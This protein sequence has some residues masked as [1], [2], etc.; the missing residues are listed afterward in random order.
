MTAQDSTTGKAQLNLFSRDPATGELSFVGSFNDTSKMP[1]PSGL[2]VSPDAA[3]C[4]SATPA[5]TP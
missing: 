2:A 5:A 4:M 1:A 3:R